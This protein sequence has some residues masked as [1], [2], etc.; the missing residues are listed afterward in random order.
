MVD[1]GYP[2]GSIQI[3]DGVEPIVLL[4][5]AVTGGGYATIATVISPDLSKI[6]QAKT[7]EKIKFVS[8]SLEQAL[9][10]RS[11]SEQRLNKIRKRVE[12][13]M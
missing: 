8:V 9:N 1:L 11:E 6:A 13:G 2:I 4:N 10:I 12:G 3:P 7:G 5:D